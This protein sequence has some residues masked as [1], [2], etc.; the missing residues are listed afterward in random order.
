MRLSLSLSLSLERRVLKR[1]TPRQA[2][3]A[4]TSTEARRNLH[5]ISTK[6]PRNLDGYSAKSKRKLRENSAETPRQARD[7]KTQRN[8]DGISTESRRNLDGNSTESRRKRQA[9]PATLR[10]EDDGERVPVAPGASRTVSIWDLDLNFEK[11][12]RL[13]RRVLD[14]R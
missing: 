2:R 10:D 11:W 1:K 5:E 14:D 13:V 4:L 9:L 3:D 8:L 12:V 7:E 6:S